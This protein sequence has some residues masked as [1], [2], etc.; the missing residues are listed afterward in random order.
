MTACRPPSRTFAA[1]E[2]NS[3]STFSNTN[4]EY[5]GTFER[6]FM[7]APAGMMW[8]VVILSPT[9]IEATPRTVAGNGSFVGGA[10]MFGPRN[11]VTLSGSATSFGKTN[12]RSSIANRFGISTF[13]YLMGRV[14]GSTMRPIRAAAA[15][16]SHETRYTWASFVP[17]RP[18]KLRFEVRSD[19]P[20]ELGDWLLPMQKPHAHSSNRAPAAIRSPREPSALIACS[21]WR[22]PGA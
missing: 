21:T 7:R 17:L 3:G 15:A 14:L 9:L 20:F 5:F 2:A 18:S 4:S 6:Y 16:V 22:E 19:T 11:I 8:S 12:I 10:P 1:R 13:G